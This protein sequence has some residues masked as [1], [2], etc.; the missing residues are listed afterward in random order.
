MKCSLV[1]VYAM[2]IGSEEQRDRCLGSLRSLNSYSERYGDLESVDWIV[3]LSGYIDSSFYRWDRL[4]SHLERECESVYSRISRVL[5]FEENVGKTH[6]VN[7]AILPPGTKQLP[8]HT[9]V[10]GK[11][12]NISCDYLASVDCD[13]LLNGEGFLFQPLCRIMEGRVEGGSWNGRVVRLVAPNHRGDV[14]HFANY[15]DTLGT[16]G[17]E[18]VT[19]DETT[20]CGM[21]GGLLLMLVKD[22][23]T[24]GGYEDVTGGP[25]Q[26]EDYVL[27]RS[28]R[29]R[30]YAAVIVP[31]LFVTHPKEL[32]VEFL[33]WKRKESLKSLDAILRRFERGE[34]IIT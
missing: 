8:Y 33:E 28:M 4:I 3:V 16:V 25:Y 19:Y 9:V 7:A 13:I 18:I 24:L 22:F 26:P 15:F 32:N 12:R 34:T 14:R 21:A 20:A 10:M 6:Y 31:N 5:Q 29:D 23:V 11:G 27:V 17:D 1:L 30:G 2:Y